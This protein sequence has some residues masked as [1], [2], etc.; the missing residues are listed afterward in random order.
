MQHL[1]ANGTT[2]LIDIAGSRHKREREQSTLPSQKKMILLSTHTTRLSF[3][4]HTVDHHKKKKIRSRR[5]EGNGGKKNRAN[6][7]RRASVVF[8]YKHQPSK[9]Q[10][11]VGYFVFFFFF[12]FTSCTVK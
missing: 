8:Q 11:E 6:N 2:R 3:Y 9:S 4:D 1:A 5:E 12:S 10:K 7:K